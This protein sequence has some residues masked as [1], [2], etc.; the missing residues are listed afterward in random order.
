MPQI[1][2]VKTWVPGDSVDAAG[3]NNIIDE[4]FAETALITGQTAGTPDPA[5]DYVI[6]YDA[7]GTA[8]KKCKVETLLGSGSLTD[9]DSAATPAFINLVTTT[10]GAGERLITL[11]FDAQGSNKVLAAPSDGTS[12]QPG[13]R[14]LVPADM[15]VANRDISVYTIDCSLSNV[16]SKTLPDNAAHTFVLINGASGQ[17]IKVWLKRFGTGGTGV[18]NW[19][20]TGGDIRWPGGTVPVMTTGADKIDI[21]EFLCTGANHF[22]GIRW[23]ADFQT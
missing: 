21:F 7:A 23:G 1:D 11:S 14:T 16:F 8:L 22:H 10:P 2:T 4:A 15:T 19:S 18:I 12:G 13:F 17:V 6:F 20:A 9:V 3:M 5:T